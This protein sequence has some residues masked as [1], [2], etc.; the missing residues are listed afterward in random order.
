MIKTGTATY[1]DW[2]SGFG[3]C[4][5][6]AKKAGARLVFAFE[7]DEKI[8][9]VYR[10]NLGN[11]IVVGD[12]L[13]SDSGIY[14]DK[15]PRTRNKE[16]RRRQD[17]FGNW[18]TRTVQRGAKSGE[19]KFKRPQFPSVTIKHDSPPCPNFSN[20]KAGGVEELMDLALA[21][22]CCEYLMYARPKF[23]TLENVYAYRNS[24]SFKLIARTL[25]QLGY[26]WNYWHVNAADYAVPQTRKRMIVIARR[27]GIRPMLPEAR[28]DENPQAG[29]FGTKRRWVGWY[30]AIED[31]IPGLP[32]SKFAD[33]QLERMP[34]ESAF[35]ADGQANSGGDCI[36]TRN[37]NEPIYTITTGTGHKRTAKAKL[38]NGRVVKMTPRAL[39]RFQSFPDW[40]ELPE[41]NSLAARGIGNA[42]PPLLY[43]RIAESLL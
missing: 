32:D 40:Y 15:F 3:G 35:I 24:E 26:S 28:R 23:Y 11:H 30:E 18:W 14:H 1:G 5:V 12:I 6:G 34:D 36:A 4:S 41:S 10:Q 37:N 20:A 13:M 8:A 25:T 2:F 29:L 21:R 42:V 39:A 22:K 43:Q 38:Q 31:L 7:R 16:K 9:V 19:F 27:D 17:I 33:W